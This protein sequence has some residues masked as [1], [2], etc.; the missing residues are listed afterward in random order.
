MRSLGWPTSSTPKRKENRG[1]R[2]SRCPEKC[3]I[4]LGGV[5][6]PD[7]IRATLLDAESLRGLVNASDLLRSDVPAVTPEQ[8]LDTVMR[9]F[10]GKN[11][12]ELPVVDSQ[13]TR[14]LDGRGF[15]GRTGVNPR[16]SGALGAGGWQL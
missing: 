6:G 9:I 5:I 10:G 4:G 7:E 14:R 16:Q 8:D 1:C 11:R 12:E 2:S 3:E 15:H 13:L